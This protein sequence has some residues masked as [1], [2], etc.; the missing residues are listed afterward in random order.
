MLRVC[1]CR[2]KNVVF[3]HSGNTRSRDPRELADLWKVRLA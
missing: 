3:T 2:V 1:G